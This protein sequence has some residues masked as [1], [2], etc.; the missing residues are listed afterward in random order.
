[1]GLADAQRRLNG[2]PDAAAAPP[3]FADITSFLRETASQMPI[4]AMV[5]GTDFNLREPM[6]VMHAL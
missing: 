1:M 6:Y 4:G 2:Q 3:V 5:Y